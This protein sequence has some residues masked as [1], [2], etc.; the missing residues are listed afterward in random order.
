[1]VQMANNQW[2]KTCK[3]PLGLGEVSEREDRFHFCVTILCDTHL[4]S[5][6]IFL[7]RLYKCL[8]KQFF[9][10]HPFS[11]AHPSFA[12]IYQAWV[13][14]VAKKYKEKKGVFFYKK[15]KQHF[16]ICFKNSHSQNLNE[17]QLGLSMLKLQGLHPGT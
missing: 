11:T 10:P 4:E 1:M 17:F 9:I 13:K 15:T 2:F 3:I 7:P 6:G 12:D 14:A 16:K 5:Q 8:W